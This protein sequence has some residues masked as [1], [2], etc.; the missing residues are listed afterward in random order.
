MTI[1]LK[2]LLTFKKTMRDFSRDLMEASTQDEI[3]MMY[4]E[5]NDILEEEI[6]QIQSKM[7]RQYQP[8]KKVAKARK[9][10]K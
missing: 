6:G 1:T 7:R 10:A 4:S 2:Q 5:M 8:K 9:V 3:T